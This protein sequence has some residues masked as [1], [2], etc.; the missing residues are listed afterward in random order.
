MPVRLGLLLVLL[1]GAL[2]AYLTAFNPSRVRVALSPSLAYELPLMA[3]PVGAFL[4]GVCLTLFGVLLRDLGRSFR[5][6]RIAH[7]LRGYP[8]RRA[9]G[10]A[11]LYHRG[12]DA[13]L[14]GRTSSAAEAYE[15]VL[16][17]EP[18]H[19]DA[20]LRLA[21][22]ARAQGD[23][24]AALSHDRQAATGGDRTHG[25]LALAGDYRQMGRV[26]DAL[27]TYRQIV[28]RD[29]D[30]ATALRAIR[31]LTASA[32]RW[33]EALETQERLL[34]LAGER[35]RPAELV[36]LAGIH[37]EIGKAGMGE[38][39]LG[40][41]RRLF[42]EALKADRTFLPAHLALGDAWERAGDRREAIRAWRRAAELAPVPVLLRRLEQA[43]R[44]EGK[45]SQMIALYQEALD[46]VP[47]DLALSF[48][49]GR[50]YFELEMLDEAA[51]QFQKVE[52]RAPDLAPIHGFL[53]AIYERRGQG[54]E[55]FEEYRK[56]LQLLQG[57]DW[58][59]RCSACGAAQ[60]HWQDRCAACGR[61]NTSRA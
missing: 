4:L 16:T 31:E 54:R 46:R 5:G 47:Q 39:R 57:F 49:L 2:V 21:E 15:S 60:A 20:H 28:Q 17:R 25:L 41:A 10:L 13:Q 23:H 7:P 45:P 43:Y 35:E 44:A 12:V 6:Y 26:E 50:V 37:Y 55:A 36:W 14:A 61:W 9:E 59:H 22:L 8:A 19:S 52:V 58:P 18:G 56:A 33:E 38:G 29:R 40:E 32:G 1:F 53:G 30:H 48:A 3:L 24:E 34:S 51:D 42:T 11:D 27:A